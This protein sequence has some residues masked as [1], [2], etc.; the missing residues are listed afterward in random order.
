MQK[1]E[2][3]SKLLQIK[4]L[5]EQLI[6]N[7]FRLK[8]KPLSIDYLETCINK[9]V[10]YLEQPAQ[11]ITPEDDQKAFQNKISSL[12]TSNKVRY[13]DYNKYRSI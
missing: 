9:Y 10:K 13:N 1:V 11:S 3:S 7:Q 5:L 6:L 8:Q 4:K 12:N 2:D